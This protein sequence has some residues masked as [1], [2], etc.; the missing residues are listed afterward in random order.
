[1]TS[2]ELFS[3]DYFEARKRFLNEADTL[4]LTVETIVHPLES[5]PQGDIAIDV[6][7]IGPTK[8]ERLLFVLSGVHGTE[9]NAGSAVQLGLL[10]D[11]AGKV[12]DN[13]AIVLIHAVNPV[14]CARLTRYDENNVDPNRNVRDFSQPLP[15]NPEYD[16]MHSALC[17]IEWTGPVREKADADIQSYID[18]KGFDSFTQNVLQGQHSHP[19]GI[20]FG[21][22]EQIWCVKQ[23]IE[24]MTRHAD[25][26]SK[27]SLIDVHTGIG[28]RGFG[29]IIRAGDAQPEGAEWGKIGGMISDIVDM[30]PSAESKIKILIEF[31][32]HEFETVIAAHRADNWLRRRGD[33]NSPEG[34]EIR[35]NLHDALFVD[36]ADWCQSIWE[37]SRRLTTDVL[38]EMSQHGI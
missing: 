21:G 20:F 22:T 16:L 15:E 8:T 14:G 3:A 12:P 18:S 9:I 35:K 1:M 29:Q 17:P 19:D 34:L 13:T 7:R 2:H 27:V 30:I 23:L 6:I 28:P 25:G 5:D 32:T 10:R 11:Y 24:I 38:N 37:Q 33:R 4:G 31:G 26:A 36:Q